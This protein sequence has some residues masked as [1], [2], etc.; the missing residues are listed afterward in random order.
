MYVY[1]YVYGRS[2]I[3][4][5]GWTFMCPL[6]ACMYV[7]IGETGHKHKHYEQS[8]HY[9]SSGRAWMRRDEKRRGETDS[10]KQRERTVLFSLFYVVMCVL[11]WDRQ[12]CSCPPTCL[13]VLRARLASHTLPLLFLSLSGPLLL[14]VGLDRRSWY[15]FCLL[16]DV[17]FSP[18]L[19]NPI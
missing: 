10:R 8:D 3:G 11:F 16:Q 19:P 14:S 15:L 5:D 4:W 18:R 13:S 17:I 12:F 1:F 6:H 9:L 2:E 7:C